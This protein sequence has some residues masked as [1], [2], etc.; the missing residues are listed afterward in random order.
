MHPIGQLSIGCMLRWRL[1]ALASLLA[2]LLAWGRLVT[3]VGHT[4]SE[5]WVG[6]PGNGRLGN[7]ERRS[8]SW[9]RWRGERLDWGLGRCRLRGC[10]WG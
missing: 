8:G 9:A 10:C 6:L 3:E 1:L 5:P 2:S 7:W 4:R